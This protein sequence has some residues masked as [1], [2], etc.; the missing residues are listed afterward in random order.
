MAQNWD[1]QAYGRE[2]AFVHKLA[3]GVVEWLDAKPGERILDLGCGDGQLTAQLAAI[4][5]NITGVDSS[6]AMVEAAKSRGIAA[7]QGSAEQLPFP[8]NQF[9][10]V[11]SNAALHWVRGQDEMMAEVHRVL[12]RGGRFVVEMGGHGNIAAIRVALMAV[13]ARHGYAY[14]EDG[15]NYYPTPA[16]YRARLERHGFSIERIELI[17]RPTPLPEGGMA[18][19][20]N[21]F[22]RGVLDGLPQELRPAIVNETCA[23]LEPALK[24]ED[25]GWVADYVRLRF[26]AHAC[27]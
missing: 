1:P 2:G 7:E 4:G 15:V 8:A 9:D 20:L 26:I 16:G 5:T 14:R 22:R 6:A 27:S 13:L 11:F 17:P 18:G 23:L 25:G 3:G 21:T 19:W 12:K 24:D 10:A